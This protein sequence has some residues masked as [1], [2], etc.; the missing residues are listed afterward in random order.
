M[1]TFVWPMAMSRAQDTAQT[2]VQMMGLLIVTFIMASGA[3]CLE[4]PTV[5]YVQYHVA[6]AHRQGL[7]PAFR[8]APS[9]IRLGTIQPSNHDGLSAMRPRL[10]ILWPEPEEASQ[11]RVP[12]SAPHKRARD[13]AISKYS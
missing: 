4:T 10:S 2:A 5:L 3:N 1:V 6:A 13:I 11:H 7:V 8:P 12:C 9:L